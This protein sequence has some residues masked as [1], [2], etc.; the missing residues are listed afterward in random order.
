[1]W[2]ACF[3][4]F[5]DFQHVN[6]LS[7]VS[8][9]IIYLCILLDFRWCKSGSYMGAGGSH[10]SRYTLVLESSSLGPEEVCEMACSQG[11]LPSP[12][13]ARGTAAG[14]GTWELAQSEALGG[15]GSMGCVGL[16]VVTSAEGAAAA[17]LHLCP[18]CLCRQS[19]E[20]SERRQG[21]GAVLLWVK[22]YVAVPRGLL[23]LFGLKED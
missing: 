9:N 1:M 5:Y 20:Q 11:G 17:F 19:S 13:A 2:T 14:T 10:S 7:P 12:G 4:A 8:T 3:K 21:R 16:V 15:A 22:W 23:H 6:S 18:L